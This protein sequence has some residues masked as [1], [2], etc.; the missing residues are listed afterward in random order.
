MNN[1]PAAPQPVSEKKTKLRSREE[2]EDEEYE[3]GTI[4]KKKKSKTAAKRGRKEGGSKQGSFT[5]KIKVGRI[6]KKRTALSNCFQ[7][8][9][10]DVQ[11][12]A[13]V[14]QRLLQL[15][16]NGSVADLMRL[17]GKK[18]TEKRKGKDKKRNRQDKSSL[19]QCCVVL[20]SLQGVGRKRAEAIAHYRQECGADFAFTD[21]SELSKCGFGKKTLENFLKRNIFVVEGLQETNNVE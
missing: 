2:E 7:S 18:R 13:E 20:G 10:A 8:P 21:V 11:V 17:G 9:L 14:T 4:E 15:C 16:S 1:A 6:A 5:K 3:P 12:S 19:S